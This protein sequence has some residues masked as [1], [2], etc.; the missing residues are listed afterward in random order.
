MASTKLA[1]RYDVLRP[2]GSGSMGEVFL[3]R[4]LVEG[5]VRAL[6]RLRPEARTCETL[7]RTEFE[8]LTTLNHP[9]IVSVYNYGV[10]TDHTP[11]YTMDYVPSSPLA[12]VVGHSGQ[13]GRVLRI[14]SEVAHGLEVLHGRKIV[15]GDLK[16]SNV[17]VTARGE[18][19]ESVRLV[20]F[21]LA[22]ALGSLEGAR[23]GTW[24]FV[25]PEVLR[26]EPPTIASDLYSLGAT[27]FTL[28]C[29]K[30]PFPGQT[31]S[32]VLQHQLHG[33]VDRLPLEKVGAPDQ[34]VD[35]I[36]QLL[37]V[38]PRHRLQNA[39]D[40][41]RELESIDP[42]IA[43]DLAERLGNAPF[44][45]R[46]REL[47][48]VEG[49]LGRPFPRSHMVLING[50]RGS[51]KSAYLREVANRA[52]VAG[53]T[54]ASFQGAGNEPL[55]TMLEALANGSSAFAA[56]VSSS[57]A[58]RSAAIAERWVINI[59]NAHRLGEYEHA[60]IR[61][62]LLD[63][64]K[65]PFLLLLAQEQ[66][67]AQQYDEQLL[68]SA[69]VLDVVELGALKRKDV[70]QLLA[71]RLRDTSPPVLTNFV[72]ERTH[73]HPALCVEVLRQAAQAGIVR[74]SDAG[75]IVDS[76]GLD[77]LSVP[78]SFEESQLAVIE[79]LPAGARAAMTA[80][81]VARSAT[82]EELQRIVGS[83]TN[84]DLSLLL[85]GGLITQSQDERYQLVSSLVVPPI[86][87]ERLKTL[88]RI[89][90]QVLSLSPTERFWHYEGAGMYREALEAAELLPEEDPNI[91]MAAAAMAERFDAEL[92]AGWYERTARRFFGLGRYEAAV[93]HLEQSLALAPSSPA[94]GERLYLAS[95]AHLRCGNIA[96]SREAIRRALSSDWPPSL[97]S[98]L[99]TNE[100][101]CFLQLGELA[102][103]EGAAQVALDDAVAA[104]DTEAEAMA[105]N[106]LVY[107]LLA[108]GRGTSAQL[109]AQRALDASRRNCS[110]F[111]RIRAEGACAAV[112]HFHNDRDGA[113]D[114]YRQALALAREYKLRQLVEELLINLSTVLTD[115]G[116]WES[117][118]DANVEAMRLALEDH[119]P[120]SAAVALVNLAHANALRGN[121]RTAR[122]EARRAA[123]L[124]HIHVSAIESSAWRARARAERYAG[125]YLAGEQCARRAFD[126]ANTHGLNEEIGWCAL[127][128]GAA[129]AQQ[130][131]S[132]EAL[133]VWRHA[134]EQL[135]ADSHSLRCLLTALA[136]SEELRMGR[137]VEALAELAAAEAIR[138]HGNPLTRAAEMQLLRL[139]SEVAAERGDLDAAMAAA[140]TLLT[141]L[142][143]MPAPAEYALSAARLA[144]LLLEH[145]EC[146]RAPLGSWLH[147]AAMIFDRIGNHRDERRI[148]LLLLRWYQSRDSAAY[149][150]RDHRVIMDAIGELVVAD[151]DSHSFGQRAIDYIV[152]Q[153][154]AE[155]GV[156]LLADPK[157]SDLVPIA[158][159]GGVD[160]VVRRR[161]CKYSRQAVQRVAGGRTSFLVADAMK[162]PRA[163][164]GSVHD[165]GLR[166]IVCV[167]LQSDERILGVIYLDDSRQARTFSQLDQD[168][169][170]EIAHLLVGAIERA[171]G[172]QE[173]ERRTAALAHENRAMREELESQFGSGKLIGTS[174]AMTRILTMIERAAASDITVLL[175]GESGSGKELIAR[176]IHAASKRRHRE[177]V[178]LHCGAIPDGLAESEILGISR[179][180]ATDVEA[181]DGCFQDANGGTLFLDE[182]GDMPRNQQRALFRALS[183]EEVRK[184]G[185]KIVDRID[186]RI[187]VATNHDLESLVQKGEFR[188]ELLHRINVFPIEVPPLRVR[189]EDIPALAQYFAEE[190]AASEKRVAPTFSRAFLSAL[191]QSN[192]PGNVRELS[193]YIRKMIV[194][195]SG[196][197]LYPNPLPDDLEKQ[198]GFPTVRSGRLKEQLRSF[199]REIIMRTLVRHERN[200]SQ[201]AREL[202][203][204][205]SVLRYRIDRL[206]LKG[207]R[208][209]SRT[210]RKR[211]G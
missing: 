139:Q 93:P 137:R 4:D 62:S 32:A 165:L 124:C 132:S 136:G 33:W 116:R 125:R 51:G 71:A 6:K 126:L 109:M 156:L 72:F 13:W 175:T 181:R 15:H 45:G 106:T 103:A 173:S 151:I 115:L 166:S 74:E 48:I 27:L 199:E 30:Q 11:F 158:E 160:G 148:H 102:A 191:V 65:R 25:A 82:Y 97:R 206:E 141:Q 108:A 129:L 9:T 5:N 49:F 31:A 88:H 36:L 195:T 95:S 90:L 153:L 58:S 190:F 70:E 117:V 23:R 47:A 184:V 146:A 69:G 142:D 179:K 118:R 55:V 14:G 163:E 53:H 208:K 197:V 94:A 46:E 19:I 121:T 17:L 150:V 64:R 8:T 187:I 157:T 42:A 56:N 60:L 21:G 155:H 204:S 189:K 12:E 207:G 59:D 120:R 105:A 134:R 174:P 16:P 10:A 39:K 26:G 29:G 144:E 1:K 183:E 50:P 154:G 130:G 52:R 18:T 20:D 92:A 147:K 104:V 198:V 84:E 77:R 86:E 79:E 113:V 135:S 200:Q 68:R 194:L 188:A 138:A 196:K 38:D 210:P 140:G 145:P 107:I 203:I 112:A 211:T 37:A 57:R 209:K 89:A 177:F 169:L 168:L 128:Y 114:R 73:G 24:G 41:R 91:A 182:I 170:E 185:A 143:L 159:R 178:A 7:L 76:D 3:V 78:S 85:S 180:V 35:V 100:A 161:A 186:A 202:G 152:D 192:W 110:P 101:G 67:E 81:G 75:L 201:A 133:S 80:I 87:P 111:V 83:V 63:S 61:Q 162:D 34:L 172:R 123:E 193:N 167:P 54:I 149:R 44:V 171:R 28:G 164:S 96:Q 98:R 40:L 119:R 122:R 127:E 176:A 43:R 2:L 131:Q 205:E 22:V 99:V 66:S